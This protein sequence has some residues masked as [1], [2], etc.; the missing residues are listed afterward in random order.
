MAQRQRAGLIIP[1]TQD[2]NLL[3]VFSNSPALQKLVVKAR[4]TQ[5]TSP[6]TGVAQTGERGA[7]NS[8]VTRSK[9]V[10]GIY[11]HIAMVHQG[12]GATCIRYGAEDA[13][14]VMAA[15][16]EPEDVGSKLTAG[17][18]QF[19][20]FTEAGRH[21]SSDVKHEPFTGVAQRKRAGLITPRSLVRAQSPVSTIC[22]L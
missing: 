10:S 4:A 18:F 16:E 12:T 13:R 17:F 3:P 1:R 20:S 2:R 6:F 5:N 14:G 19:A 7:H 22:R 15:A 21:S 11:L 9:R 8:E